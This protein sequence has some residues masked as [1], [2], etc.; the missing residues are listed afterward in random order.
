MTKSLDYDPFINNLDT[1][2]T[3]ELLNDN[4]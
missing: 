2:C 1:E 4:K 3:D